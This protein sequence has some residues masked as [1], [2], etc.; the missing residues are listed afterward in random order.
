[1]ERKLSSG[2]SV[3]ICCFNSEW[4]I[5]RCLESLKQQIIPDGLKWE[6]ILINN[7][8]TDNTLAVAHRT[9][10]SS[11]V[12]FRIFD[13]NKAGLY[14]ARKKGIKEALFDKVIFCDDDNLLS[15]NY[16]ATMAALLEETPSLGAVGGKG[17]AEFESDPDPRILSKL[18]AY[19]VDSQQSNVENNYLFGAGLTLRTQLVRHVYSSQ[20]CYLLGRKGGDLLSGDDSELVKSVILRGF[21]IAATE[22]ASYTHVLASHRLSLDYYNKMDDGFT[23]AYPVLLVM[24]CVLDGI[25]FKK[26]WFEYK[27]YVKLY[28]KSMICNRTLE[29]GYSQNYKAFHY[30]GIFKLLFI[31]IEWKRIKKRTTSY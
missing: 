15:S 1:M 4:I 18:H 8:C 31:Y 23:L 9:M 25:S 14:F 13:E 29:H 12:Y 5:S 21:K 26:V 2:V 22:D 3:I 17:Y 7:N 6:V 10:D 27:F 20:R 16:I 24:D 28:L 30:W 19:A 11:P